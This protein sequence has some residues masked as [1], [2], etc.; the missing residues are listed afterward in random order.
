MVFTA[1]VSLVAGLL[2]VLAP[3]VL[4]LLPVILGGSV[5]R[6]DRDRWGPFIIT[7]SLVV[8]L[9]LFTLL[10][11][12]STVFIH[13]DPRVWTY[14]S[15]GIILVL[16]VSM[17]FPGLWPRVAEAVGLERRSQA[18]LQ[19]AHGHRNKTVRPTRCRWAFARPRFIMLSR[20]IGCSHGRSA[21]RTSSS[22]T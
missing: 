5:L 16:G 4:P 8:S 18:L 14:L 1:F 10:L 3:C 7:G 11:K 6:D 15:G 19:K 9:V 2:T 12:V 22:P 13:V 17:L 20:S 21:M